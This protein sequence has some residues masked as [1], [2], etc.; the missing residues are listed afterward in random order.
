[1]YSDNFDMATIG[2]L[3]TDKASA[4]KNTKATITRN[5]FEFP[6]ALRG[7]IEKPPANQGEN[8]EHFWSFLQAVVE[9]EARAASAVGSPPST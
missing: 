2:A 4:D 6:S 5:G 7:L 3:S 1:M 9:I 8:S